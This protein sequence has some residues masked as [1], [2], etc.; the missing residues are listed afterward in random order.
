MDRLYTPWRFA[1]V[2]G[3][4]K[5]DGCVFCHV[6]AAADDHANQ[7]LHRGDHWVVMLNRYPYNNGHLLLVLGRHAALLSDCTPPELHEMGR[8]LA[9]MERALDEGLRP[10]GFNCGYNGGASAGAGIPEH[11][12]LHLLP[13]WAGDTNFMTTVGQ[14]RVMPQTL[15]QVQALLAPLLTRILAEGS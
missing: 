9:A 10:H 7:V 6:L 13:R 8:L 12:H 15:D 14:T 11:L 2:T 1:Y 3:A 4:S 5:D